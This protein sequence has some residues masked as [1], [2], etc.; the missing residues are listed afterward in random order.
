MKWI[1]SALFIG[2]DLPNQDQRVQQA[3]GQR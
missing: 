3:P 2:F 1:E